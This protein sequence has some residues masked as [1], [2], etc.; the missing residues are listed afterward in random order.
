[1][2]NWAGEVPPFSPISP[3][4]EGLATPAPHCHQHDAEFQQGAAATKKNPKIVPFLDFP[5]K[6][7][8]PRPC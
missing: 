4:A 2:E 6:Q 8:D 1:M 5:F 3:R 7:V